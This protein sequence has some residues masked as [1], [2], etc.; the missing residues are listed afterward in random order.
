MGSRSLNSVTSQ[1]DAWGYY[2]GSGRRRAI[3]RGKLRRRFEELYGN[4]PQI[5]PNILTRVSGHLSRGEKISPP[6][7]GKI[8]QIHPDAITLLRRW[9]KEYDPFHWGAPPDLG[10][11]TPEACSL[12][13]AVLCKLDDKRWRKYKNAS[14]IASRHQLVYVEGVAFGP[15]MYAILHAW[16][17]CGLGSKKE[18]F[19]WTFYAY[20]HRIIYFGVA[21]AYEEHQQICRM[22]GHN[23]RA[24][25]FFHRDWFNIKIKVALTKILQ[26][27]KRGGKKLRKKAVT[28]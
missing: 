13:A 22:L 2:Q 15:G 3:R 5:I 16:N 8:S 19:D 7:I 23:T 18:A 26:A 21:M 27:R 28:A 4:K 10:E 24:C 1:R 6:R 14:L 17:A 11:P 12:N 9:G 20:N 25:L